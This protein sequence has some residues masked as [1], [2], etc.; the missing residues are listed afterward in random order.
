MSGFRRIVTGHDENGRSIVV[1]DAPTPNV[2]GFLHNFWSLDS[3]PCDIDGADPMHSDPKGL[4][5]PKKGVM[6]R[7]FQI[8]PRSAFAAMTDEQLWEFTRQRFVAMGA[9]DAL[10]DRTRHPAMHKTHSV[11]FIVLLSGEVTLLLDEADVPMKPFDVVVQ[12]GSNHAWENNG[13]EIAT[14]MAVLVD[15]A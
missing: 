1:E 14:L 9:E 11:D 15:G 10:V 7:F 8:P 3:V 5:P 2:N 12:R 6:F 4:H 13:K